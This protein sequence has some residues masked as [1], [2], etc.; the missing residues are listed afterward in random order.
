MW[1]ES[2]SIKAAFPLAAVCENLTQFTASSV[3]AKSDKEG[4]YFHFPASNQKKPQKF[5][6]R[7][8]L[9]RSPNNQ[10]ISFQISI[11]ISATSAELL[12]FQ[13]CLII[14]VESIN[15]TRTHICRVYLSNYRRVSIICAMSNK[16]LKIIESIFQFWFLSQIKP[17][18]KGKGSQNKFF[19]C[20]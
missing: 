19:L 7:A 12:G 10:N 6:E 5:D 2:G 13:L 8:L 20:R 9:A 14:I 4:K 15:R 3:L 17:V 16:L 11:A 1:W 18:K